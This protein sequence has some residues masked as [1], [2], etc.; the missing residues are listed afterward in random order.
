MLAAGPTGILLLRT[1][2]HFVLTMIPCFVAAS[3]AAWRGARDHALLGFTGL[4]GIAANGYLAFWL[5]FLSPPIGH[6]VSFLLPIFGIA[7]LLWIGRK[8]DAPARAVVKSL[9]LPA[10]LV[11]CAALLTL[12]AGF[13]YGGIDKPLETP[14]TRFSHRLPPD[15]MLP[16]LFAEEV[17]IGRFYK[18]FFEGGHS[19]DRPPLQAG[20]ALSQYPFLPRPRESGYTS[21]GVI[22]QSLWIFAM[23]LLLR[24]F[25]LDPRIITLALLVTLFSGFT[26]LNSFFVWPKLLAAA[27]MIGFSAMLLVESCAAELTRAA[28]LMILAGALLAFSLLSHGGSAFALI[29]VALAAAALRQHL[30][31]KSIGIVCAAAFVL[32]LPWLLYQKLFDPPGDALLKLHLAGIDHPGNGSFLSALAGAYRAI[33]P[34]IFFQNKIANARWAFDYENQ[35]FGRLFDLLSAVRRG[36]SSEAASAALDIRS[37]A[38][39]H[40]MPNLGFLA[41]GIVAFAAGIR[42]RFRSPV[43]RV[44]ARLWLVVI[45]ILIPW[46]LLMFKPESTSIHQGSYVAVLFAYSAAILALCSTARWLAI[47][48][49]VLQIALNFAVYAFPPKPGLVPGELVTFIAALIAMLWLL[50]ARR[51]PLSALSRRRRNGLGSVNPWRKS[52]N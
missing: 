13:L 46:C 16:F 42:K 19:S 40:F 6:A 4:A 25:N 34:H 5:W 14:W 7:W 17:R 28:P 27:F 11:L 38:F 9:A 24:A 49:A 33:S 2:S 18:P 20:I 12:S 44:S 47:A 39:F 52:R 29:G 3:F 36:R 50:G 8:L 23:W 10:A 43:W 22:L 35:F 32:Y 31:L 48:I 15:N 26:F 51:L 37:L 45:C 21:L 41:A 1:L 30:P